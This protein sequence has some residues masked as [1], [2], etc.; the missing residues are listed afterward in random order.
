MAGAYKE[1]DVADIIV[2][3][4]LVQVVLWIWFFGC[5]T[6]YSIGKYLLV[7]GIGIKSADFVMLCL[8]SICFIS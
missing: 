4:V 6:T 5:I 3:I 7:E 2:I 8:Y 1:N